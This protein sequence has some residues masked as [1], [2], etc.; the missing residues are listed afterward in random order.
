[1]HHAKQRIAV[2]A[3]AVASS[4]ALGMPAAAAAPVASPVST[5]TTVGS[6]V[7]TSTP[8]TMDRDRRRR[9]HRGGR[10]RN[11]EFPFVSP[12]LFGGGFSGFEGF[13][14]FD[15]FDSDFGGRCSIFLATGDINSYILCRV[16]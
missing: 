2:A 4:V 14:G 5:S 12:F 1:M 16:G 3:L 8:N 10:F 13:G 11:F 9:H 15:G 6:V 7:S